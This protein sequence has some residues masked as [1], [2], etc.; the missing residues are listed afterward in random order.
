MGPNNVKGGN[1]GER[2]EDMGAQKPSKR[3]GRV[4]ES[5]ICNPQSAIR[6]PQ[7]VGGWTLYLNP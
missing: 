1:L 3:T 6:N 2:L 7:W 4:G 5:A